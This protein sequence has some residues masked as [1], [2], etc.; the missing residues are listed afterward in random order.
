VGARSHWRRAGT[1]G[2]AIA[3]ALLPKCPACWSAYAGLSSLLG[4]S[5]V[6]D[7]RY[8]L[9]LTS[10]LLVLALVPLWLQAR[11]GRGHGP[12]LLACA[13]AAATLL[14]KFAVESDVLLYGGLASLLLASLWSRSAPARLPRTIAVPLL[15]R[16]PSATAQ[17]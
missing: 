14:G 4:L 8:L 7:E 1:V 11:R 17:N 10:G 12:W 5:F 16:L 3:V 2:S 13:A 6:V 15:R 9:P